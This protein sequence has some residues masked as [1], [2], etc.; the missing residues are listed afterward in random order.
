[1][2]IFTRLLPGILWFL[3]IL[4]LLTIPGKD[5]PEVSWM[6]YI[7]G[8]KLIHMFLFFMLTFLF[9]WGIVSS[10]PRVYSRKLV[11][12]IA[13][14]GLLYGIALEFVQKYW[15]PNRSFDGW[16]IVADGIGSFLPLLLAK[17][18]FGKLKLQLKP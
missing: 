10:K 5:L 1:M 3:F 4:Y 2:K 9:Y 18:I 11:L 15:I 8:D 13:I 14:L 12:V 7:H 16:D 6:D 17:S